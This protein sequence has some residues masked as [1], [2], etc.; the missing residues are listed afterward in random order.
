MRDL[1]RDEESFGTVFVS[2]SASEEFTQDGVVPRN[3]ITHLLSVFEF[4]FAR[5]QPEYLRLLY[6][7]KGSNEPKDELRERRQH[8]EGNP[9]T[10][11][12][13]A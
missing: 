9:R 2:I 3:R 11:T 13:S 8:D 12:L 4:S 6:S 10:H 7:G 1:F 5:A